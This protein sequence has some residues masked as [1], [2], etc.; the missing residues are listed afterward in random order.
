MTPIYIN[1]I[2]EIDRLEREFK[3]NA[4]LIYEFLTGYKKWLILMLPSLK[5]NPLD[6]SFCSLSNG[7]F[8]IRIEELFK[9][10]EV[11]FNHSNWAMSSEAACIV[12]TL[13]TLQLRTEVLE[14]FR[15][16]S[17][18]FLIVRNKFDALGKY[19]FLHKEYNQ[20]LSEA[21]GRKLQSYYCLND[22]FIGYCG[23]I[24]EADY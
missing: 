5:V 23:E 14:C 13:K 21:L 4:E 11:K 7:G 9:Q 17:K 16:D 6:F 18:E 3:Q 2:N 1:S 22:K 24:N 12:L 8:Y 20:I 15:P 10:E 19:A